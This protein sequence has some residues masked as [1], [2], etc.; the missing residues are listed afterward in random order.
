[1][2]N[3]T[4]NL[5]SL[6]GQRLF[7]SWICGLSR[8]SSD[9]LSLLYLAS[10]KVAPSPPVIIWKLGY[11]HGCQLIL[12]F[13]WD[14]SCGYLSEHKFCDHYIWPEVLHDMVAG[15]SGWPFVEKENWDMRESQIEA[16]SEFMTWPESYKASLHSVCQGSHKELPNLSRRQMDSL[17]W[18][19][20]W[21]GSRRSYGIWNFVI[22][23]FWK[24]WYAIA[25]YHKYMAKKESYP[26][27]K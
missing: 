12:S 13:S 20:K 19:M 25:L 11:S 3:T 8:L 1:M 17:S 23:P 2:Q 15:F 16:M 26:F 6:K 14:L 22:L 18:L 7:C 21:P 9:S 4:S 5:S 10:R 27:D 24:I